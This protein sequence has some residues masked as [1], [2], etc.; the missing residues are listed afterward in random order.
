MAPFRI[1]QEFVSELENM[2]E[3]D[4]LALAE[5][6]SDPESNTPTEQVIYTYSVLFKKTNIIAH[7]EQAILQAE[8]WLA[9]M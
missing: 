5:L 9:V 8:G 7:L 3:E 1:D 2:S 6:Q 4:L